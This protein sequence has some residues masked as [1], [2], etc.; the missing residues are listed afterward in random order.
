MSG[1]GRPQASRCRRASVNEVQSGVVFSRRTIRMSLLM[2][3]LLSPVYSQPS[4]STASL[5]LRF[6][7][8]HD[9][10]AKERL[11]LRVTTQ[12]A[13]AG[14]SLL[15]LAET[16]PNTDTRWMTMRGMATLHYAVSA[17]FLVASLKDSD[18]LIRA[19]AA[20]ALADLRIR[21]ASDALLAMFA[22][23]KQAAAIEQASLALRVLN[24]KAGAPYIREKIPVFP[25]QARAWLIQALGTLG[26]APGDVPFVASYLDEMFSAMA[27][28][29]AIEELTGLSFGPKTLGLSG[30]PTPE[31]LAARA[32]WDSHRNQWPRCD[33]C[34][35]K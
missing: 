32:W 23:E 14:P 16:T 6:D 17:P 12:D 30:W 10:S 29:E 11:L 34:H 20:R 26:N 21:N 2:V 19:N 35:V 24:I 27:A 33:D 8:E 13:G 31:I 28:T 22:A 15:R 18:V 1:R 7:N 25:G 3:P 5:L 9:L 4:E